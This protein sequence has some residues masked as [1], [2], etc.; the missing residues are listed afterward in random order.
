LSQN[1]SAAWAMP[2]IAHVSARAKKLNSSRILGTRRT[3]CLLRLFRRA[4]KSATTS[5]RAFAAIRARSQ[6]MSSRKFL[7]TRRTRSRH[8]VTRSPSRSLPR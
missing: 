7:W 3:A 8:L 5:T 2:T 1:S 4:K 6:P